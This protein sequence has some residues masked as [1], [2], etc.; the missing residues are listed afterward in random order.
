MYV[1][2]ERLPNI[3]GVLVSSGIEGER[4]PNIEGVVI[5]SSGIEVIGD[6]SS[7]SYS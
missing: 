7:S 5:D 1:G 6:N 3:E 4:L 2:V